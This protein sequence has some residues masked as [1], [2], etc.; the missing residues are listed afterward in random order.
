MHRFIFSD[1]IC[2]LII[3]NC[4]LTL[5]GDVVIKPVLLL[6]TILSKYCLFLNEGRYK[7]SNGMSIR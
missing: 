3:T 1:L 6:K 4:V 2:K 7:V 5:K